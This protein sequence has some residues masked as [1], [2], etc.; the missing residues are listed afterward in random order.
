MN[1]CVLEF[2][3][4]S[5][6]KVSRVIVVSAG[7]LVFWALV[8]L[9]SQA[10]GLTKGPNAACPPGRVIGAPTPVILLSIPPPLPPTPTPSNRNLTSPLNT[11]RPAPT[12]IVFSVTETIDL[13]P[14]LAAGEKGKLYVCKKNGAYVVILIRPGTPISDLRLENGDVLFRDDPPDNAR[15]V[16][17]PRPTFATPVL[18]RT[19]TGPVQVKP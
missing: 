16:P 15:M 11:P 1:G 5:W 9:W 7:V 14:A 4:S 18:T 6:S 10:E 13:A 8:F 17:P 19:P 3:V 12:A 2:I